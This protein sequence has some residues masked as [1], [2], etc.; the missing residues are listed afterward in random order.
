MHI[1]VLRFSAIGDVAL[2]LP[3]LRGLLQINPEL[4]ITLVTQPMF[5]AF[6]RDIDRLKLFPADFKTRYR[7]FAGLLRF[8]WQLSHSGDYD[9][10][11]DLHAVIRSYIISYLFQL[12]G[13]HVYRIDKGRSEKRDL[14]SGNI[15]H[16]LKHTTQRYLDVFRNL[17]VKT[18]IPVDA[19][20]NY[21][22]TYINKIA[23]RYSKTAD[24]K[25]IGIAP[26][27]RHLLKSWPLG[28]MK[29]LMQMIQNKYKV[30][31]FI[32]GGGA[33][34]LEAI[35][36]MINEFPG[37]VNAAKE[38]DFN[39]ELDL[40]KLLDIMISMDSANTHMASLAGVKTVTIWGATHPYAGFGAYHTNNALNIQ[41]SKEELDCRPCTVFGKGSCRRHDLACLHWLT[42]E[43]VYED[44]RKAKVI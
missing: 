41:I 33:R 18:W 40:M 37:S 26:F 15:F 2:S 44:I 28:N 19:F 17:P 7:G 3:V 8:Y 23:E 20:F 25:W 22:K 42:P 29:S 11:I 34:E 5:L 1:L 13:K 31:F 32:F 9:Y 35:D 4:K 10:V 43:K 12:K 38:L 30:R 24:E 27:A 6:F 39:E 14:I 36:T 21:E 16:P